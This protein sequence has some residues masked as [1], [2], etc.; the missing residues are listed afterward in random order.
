MVLAPRNDIQGR[1]YDACDARR[2]P[3]CALY[4]TGVEGMY[5]LTCKNHRGMEYL[6]KNP[7]Q[8]TLH[9]VKVDPSV[10]E[11]LECPCPFADLVVTHEDEVE[12][13][14]EVPAKDFKYRD[15]NSFGGVR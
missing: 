13:P 14:Q 11:G 1:T 12:L 3:R 10:T 5:R 6:T 8:R 7:Y 15:Y 9:I 4:G 2:K